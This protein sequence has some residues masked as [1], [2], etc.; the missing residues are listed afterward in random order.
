MEYGLEGTLSI[1]C[2]V[3]SYCI[4]L[5]ELFTRKK[6]DD[7][8]FEENLNLR[9]WFHNVFLT[10]SIL[11]LVIVNLFSIDDRLDSNKKLECVSLLIEATLNCKEESPKERY[12]M[13]HVIST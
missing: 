3:Y 11:D 5:M 7:H 2:D 6:P 9:A 13:D 8:M 1:K 12:K 4:I 10:T